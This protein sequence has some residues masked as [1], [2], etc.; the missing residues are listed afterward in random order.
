ME[1]SNCWNKFLE[2]AEGKEIFK[3]FAYTKQK[4]IEKLSIITYSD[5]NNER[6]DA[7]TFNQKCDAFLI[8]LFYPPPASEPPD[9]SNYIEKEWDW[10]EISTD[11]IKEAIFFNSVKKAP[12][13]DQI[14]FSI[15]Q[16]A[17]TA[18]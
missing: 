1:K 16:K 18:F 15:I 7:I 11:E 13:P 2:K 10:P 3:A 5:R 17:Y 14:S 4:R 6:K 9:W 8:I 12:G